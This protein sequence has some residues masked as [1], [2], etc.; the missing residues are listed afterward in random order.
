[1]PGNRARSNSDQGGRDGGGAP[2]VDGPPQLAGLFAGGIPKLKKRQGGI[3]T[4]GA[5]CPLNLYD[6][7][8]TVG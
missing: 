3:D 8:L 5:L 7:E 2:A 1:M 4:G 6:A